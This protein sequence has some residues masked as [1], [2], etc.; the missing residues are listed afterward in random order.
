[1]ISCL[2]LI[3]GIARIILN[4]HFTFVMDC[5]LT[6][7]EHPKSFCTHHISDSN[8]TKISIDRAKTTNQKKGLK[9]NSKLNQTANKQPHLQIE[10]Q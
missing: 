8:L 2:S 9:S 5:G 6:N 7:T 10:Q 4:T 3:Y 1:M